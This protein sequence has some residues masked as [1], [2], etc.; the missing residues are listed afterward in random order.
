M[1]IDGRWLNQVTVRDSY[2][3][4]NIEEIINRLEDFSFVSSIDLSD[5]FLQIPLEE[6]SQIKTAFAIPG[7]KMY[8][9][10]RMPFGLMNSPI[11][12]ARIGTNE[13]KVAAILNLPVPKTVKQLR[14]ILGTVG[15]FRRFI[16]FIYSLKE[17]VV[18][19]TWNEKV[20]EAFSKIKELLTSAPILILSDY[21]QAF[22]VHSDASDI[23]AG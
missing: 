22:I 2:P 7:R 10:R 16:L 12:M 18:K 3:I 21:S 8:C 19:I 14:Q 20:D 17:D 13:F 1:C 23:G 6:H 15:W 5:A 4:P 11:T 9:Y